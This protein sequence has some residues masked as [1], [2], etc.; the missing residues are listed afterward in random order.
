MTVTVQPR[1]D[2]RQTVFAD[3]GGTFNN[4]IIECS[5]LF[6]GKN[7]LVEQ[8]SQGIPLP[9]RQKRTPT[10]AAS[11]SFTVTSAAHD[12]QDLLNIDGGQAKRKPF[13]HQR[14]NSDNHIR[15]EH[16]VLCKR[17]ALAYAQPAYLLTNKIVPS[18]RHA[19]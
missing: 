18:T 9:R 15:F 5:Y 2:D 17:Q 19:F 6:R 10:I 3:L 7:A 4:V 11:Q 16:K 8:Q 13:A 12:K 14:I 1:A